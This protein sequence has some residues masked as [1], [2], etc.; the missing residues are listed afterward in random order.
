MAETAGEGSQQAGRDSRLLRK[1]GRD[2]LKKTLGARSD[3]R[4]LG[5]EV[6]DLEALLTKRLGCLGVLARGKEGV[7]ERV[8]LCD[9]SSG[10]GDGS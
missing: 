8:R 1:R 5:L 3:N 10:R 9:D 6:D 2:E 4:G 7:D